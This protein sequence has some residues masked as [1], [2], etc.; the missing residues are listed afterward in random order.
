MTDTPTREVPVLSVPTPPALDDKE[1]V[2]V[3]KSP[4]GTPRVKPKQ[5]PWA[6]GILVGLNLGLGAC[7]VKA[8]D[9]TVR[10]LCEFGAI[11]VSGVIGTVSPGLRRKP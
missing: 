10:L 6:L 2:A 11:T 3:V 5:V 1:K 9:P 4:T 8:P 7:A